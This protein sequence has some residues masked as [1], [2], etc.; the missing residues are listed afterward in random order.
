M[1]IVKKSIAFL[2]ISLLLNLTSKAQFSVHEGKWKGKM[3]MYQESQL[4]DSVDVVMSITSK[5]KDSVWQWKTEYLSAKMPVTKD[6]ILRVAD[7]KKGK[8]ITDEGDGILLSDF[9]FGNKLYSQFTTEGIMLTATYEW[10]NDLLIFEVTS[11]KL[12]T[13]SSS[14]VTSYS[15]KHVQRGVLI[16]E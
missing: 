5:I 2:C 15:I 6:Y 16:K 4:M 3:M 11:G 12:D 7:R 8:F 9:G 14:E 10:R 13:S 1:S